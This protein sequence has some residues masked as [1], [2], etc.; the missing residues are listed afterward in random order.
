[1]GRCEA[2]H[3]KQL[4]LDRLILSTR[5]RRRPTQP[6]GRSTGTPFEGVCRAGGSCDAQVW[7]CRRM[8]NLP[9]RK[10]LIIRALIEAAGAMQTDYPPVWLMWRVIWPETVRRE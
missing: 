5:A 1:M 8:D 7:R 4:N 3:I 9:S 6:K 10:G 2:C